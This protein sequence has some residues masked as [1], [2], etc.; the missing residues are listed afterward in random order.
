MAWIT[1]HLMT[2]VWVA[3]MIVATVVESMTLTL[4]SVWFIPSA[5]VSLILSFFNVDIGWQILVFVVL[6]FVL[7]LFSRTIF[8][9][10]LRIKPV[11]TNAD[12]LIGE[13]A[14]VTETISNLNETGAV[15]VH[16]L[17]WTARSTDGSEIAVGE[18]VLIVRI[19]G[20]KLICT[21]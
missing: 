4:V 14:V 19:E 7:I 12:A 10:A 16:G 8:K 20:V 1:A 18:V 17:L 5:A 6:S 3:V 15:K 13:R 21:K 9:E 2:L 11:A